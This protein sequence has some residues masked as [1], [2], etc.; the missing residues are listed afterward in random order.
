MPSNC[1]KEFEGEY[2][3]TNPG[4]KMLAMNSGS[5][6]SASA[7][8]RKIIK[9]HWKNLDMSLECKYEAF[10]LVGFGFPPDWVG[11]QHARQNKGQQ[12]LEAF[13]K[14]VTCQESS[15]FLPT[16]CCQLARSPMVYKQE[17]L[18]CVWPPFF[19]VRAPVGEEEEG[20]LPMR[21]LTKVSGIEMLGR[22]DL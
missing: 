2:V 12:K 4:R 10:F 21:C 9:G 22:W 7:R 19:W 8:T 15:R 18:I 5:R 13:N 20:H 14:S 3:E 11:H 16:T 1:G 17:A 6:S